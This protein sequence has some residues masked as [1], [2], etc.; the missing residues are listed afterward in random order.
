MNFDRGIIM[1]NVE[2]ESIFQKYAKEVIDEAIEKERNPYALQR[3]ADT[4]NG[5]GRG[6]KFE[7]IGGLRPSYMTATS[8]GHQLLARIT[9][10]N[11][12]RERLVKPL[13]IAKKRLGFSHW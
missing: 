1:K 4:G 12:T 6:P 5:G 7:G 11:A 9:S 13:H 10:K 8:G 3:V 2:D